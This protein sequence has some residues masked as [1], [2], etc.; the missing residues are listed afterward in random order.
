M[1]SESRQYG[2][3]EEQSFSESDLRFLAENNISG[4]I[5]Q[6]S[7]SEVAALGTAAV[8]HAAEVS[9]TDAVTESKSSTREDV[10]PSESIGNFSRDHIAGAFIADQK[11]RQELWDR[12]REESGPF[13]SAGH[14]EMA[15]SLRQ[16]FEY[17]KQFTP[18]AGTVAEIDE[19]GKDLPDP[20]EDLTLPPDVRM[21]LPVVAL[22]HKIDSYDVEDRALSTA[23]EQY[24][25]R[26]GEIERPSARIEETAYADVRDQ[27]RHILG[28]H[29]AG[30]QPQ[31]PE[32][33]Q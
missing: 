24:A 28:Q 3:P 4:E 2:Q 11:R 33:Q 26:K 16:R 21:A 6:S 29:G 7:D 27:Y 12:Q 14:A 8:G 10:P 18:D 22:A 17:S 31:P 13:A 15:A 5:Q 19:I 32:D 30:E 1:S 9:A 20:A 23:M 25:E